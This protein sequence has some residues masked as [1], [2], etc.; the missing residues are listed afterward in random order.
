MYSIESKPNSAETKCDLKRKSYSKKQMSGKTASTSRMMEENK[1]IDLEVQRN[2]HFK[3]EE[4]STTEENS[5]TE[6][7][8]GQENIFDNYL[9]ELKN[10]RTFRKLQNICNKITD[11]LHGLPLD[12]ISV[13]IMK[14]KPRGGRK[15]SG[16]L[17]R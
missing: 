6:E 12:P 11:D 4:N 2:N 14:N 8:S 15:G 9:K 3:E 13:N 10:C 5:P 17:S 1:Q 16:Y 7:R